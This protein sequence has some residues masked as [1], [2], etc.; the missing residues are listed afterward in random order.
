MKR[1]QLI[2]SA[3]ALSIGFTPISRLL[4]NPAGPDLAVAGPR[5]PITIYNNWSAYDE[6]SDNI[7]L[8]EDLAMMEL[9]ELIRLKNSGMHVDYYMMDAFWFDKAGGFRTWHKQR[10]PNGPDKWIETCKANDIKPGMWFP[11]NDR[12]AKDNN[13]FFLDMIP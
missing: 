6:L 1:R 7:P 9:N 11:V 2:K 13:D 4:S 10:W 8:T 5:K 12:I 3:I